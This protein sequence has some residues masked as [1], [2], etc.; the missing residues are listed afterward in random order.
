MAHHA[1]HLD[2]EEEDL[3]EEEEACEEAH[4]VEVGVAMDHRHEEECVDLH[5][6]DGTAVDV[7]D[8][9]RRVCR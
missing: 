6:Q 7:A 5:L 1:V 4:M 2:L 3:T 9:H 8:A